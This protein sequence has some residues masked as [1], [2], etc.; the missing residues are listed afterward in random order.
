M[1]LG[2]KLLHSLRWIPAYLWQRIARRDADGEPTH[3]IFSIA[4]HFE[5]SIIPH[6]GR[7][8][9]NKGEQERRLEHWCEKIPKAVDK[10]RD[11]DGRPFRHTYFYPAEQ[12][13]RDLIERLADHCKEGWGEI[14]IHLHHGVDE[15][16]T[17]EN[18]KRQLLEFRDKLARN[19]CLSFWEGTGEPRY[20]FVHG[21]FA[22][23]N[24]CGN[25]YCGVDS[26]M[27]I[28]ADTG[29]YADFTLPSAPAPSQIAKINALYEC[30]LPLFEGSPHRR[31]KDLEVG[32]APRI[33]PLMI[34]GPLGIDF[35]RRKRNLPFPCIENAEIAR[36]HPPS[37][38]RVTLWEEAKIGVRGR[39]NWLFI[40]L[41][42]HGMDPRD[43]EVMFG[44][45]MQN[46]LRDLVHDANGRR[47]G[48]VHFTTAREM[49]NIMLA[50][51]D[52][53]AGN[54][55]NFRDY[56]LKPF[57]TSQ[58]MAQAVRSPVSVPSE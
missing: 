21:N 20:A 28:L 53:R 47:G 29:C 33:F 26:E 8:R 16:D 39:P 27:Q 4:N 15:P 23:A 50:T 7:A 6:N 54:P 14:E 52:G 19:G 17:A 3:L 35:S 40:K 11:A 18:T 49:V 57:Q 22:L 31:G 34:Q 58:K 55:G 46:F 42:C 13:D 48:Q 36:M 44:P 51:C 56:R 30:A 24:S 5:P 1:E 37:L 10:W 12:Y 45:P 41:H 2:R 25:R 32:R 43:S 38:K 9:A